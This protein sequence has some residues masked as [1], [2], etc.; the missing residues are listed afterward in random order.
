MKV[1]E[2]MISDV[3]RRIEAAARPRPG[4]AAEVSGRMKRYYSIWQKMKRT[5]VDA[6]QLYDILAFRVVVA[7]T[8]R[9]L[10]DARHGPPALAPGPRPDQGLHRD[11]QAQ[12]LPV[13]AHDGHGRDGP[14]LRDPDPHP[15]DGPDRRARHRGPLEVQGGPPRPPRRRRPLPVAAAARRLAERGLRPAAVPV[16]AQGRPL[17]R[18]GLHVHARRARCSPSRGAPRRSTSPTGSTRTSATAAS[19][20]GSTASSCRCARRC[21]AATS[22][23]S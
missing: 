4:V 2:G 20:R 1:S 16:V 19:A 11:A 6:A 18:R 3:R 12:L 13:A 15:R 22:S 9:L 14:A 23:R 5:G 8:A 10:R 7:E 17:P 21:R